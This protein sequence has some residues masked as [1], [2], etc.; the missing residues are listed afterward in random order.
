MAFRDA[1]AEVAYGAGAVTFILTCFKYAFDWFFDYRNATAFT[2]ELAL[3]HLPHI[4][5]TQR[6]IAKALGVEIDD[7]PPISFPGVN[8]LP[9]Q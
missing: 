6:L 5:R 1:L 4:Y 8:K 2:R 3:V 7:D 9:R